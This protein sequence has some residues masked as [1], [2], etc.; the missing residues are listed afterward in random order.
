MNTEELRRVCCIR[1]YHV[2]KKIWEAAIGEVLAYK[3]EPRND[4]DRYAVAVEKNGVI[5]DIY[6]GSCQGSV[7]SFCGERV[8]LYV[9][10]LEGEGTLEIYLKLDWKFLA[11]CYLKPQ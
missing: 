3:R 10:C 1:G 7:S 8:L 11:P 4:R 6:Q 2:Y 9:Q 5:M